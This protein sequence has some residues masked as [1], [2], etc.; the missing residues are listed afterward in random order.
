MIWSRLIFQQGGKFRLQ[1]IVQQFRRNINAARHNQVYSTDNHRVGRSF[2]NIAGDTDINGFLHDFLVKNSGKYGYRRFRQ[3][4]MD[5]FKSFRPT[6]AG[7]S[8]ISH[9]Q[10]KIRFFFNNFEN[11]GIVM[12][13]DQFN[14]GEIIPQNKLQPFQKQFMIIRYQNPH[15]LSSE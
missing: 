8:Q 4:G 10:I 1:P 7:H 14:A 13:K 12:G 2:R 15:Y 9:N 3:Q 6:A 5:F 11:L